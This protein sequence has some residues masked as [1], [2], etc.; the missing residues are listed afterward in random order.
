LRTGLHIHMDC[1]DITYLQLI[2]K[3]VHYI[4]WEP[5]IYA[6]I[7]G[8]REAN[9]FCA[10]WYKCEGT[11]VD[12]AKVL[13]HII[14]MASAEGET[15]AEMTSELAS[16]TEDL[17][18]YAGLNL[19]PLKKYGSVEFRQMVATH[20]FKLVLKWMNIILNLKR[21]ALESPES[22]MAIIGLTES[23]GLEKQLKW[24]FG[25][26][27]ALEMLAANPCI[28]D[29]VRQIGIPNAVEF[30]GALTESTSFIDNSKIFNGKMSKGAARWL[31]KKVE[32]EERKEP[33]LPR[34]KPSESLSF[35][36]SNMQVGDMEAVFP[37][38]PPPT[39]V[40]QGTNAAYVIVD[41]Y[42]DN[43]SFDEF[44]DDSEET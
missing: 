20:D 41:D 23:K 9:N 29:E 13:A 19:R 11:I 5:A 18:K 17:H 31:A 39:P 38:L 43:V 26:E 33:P 37:P 42:G 36:V 35:Y 1:R 15:L 12:A 30:L 7:G 25:E 40:I 3:V 10:P 2:G 14:K 32:P 27:T 28:L 6:W 4:M 8:G 44:N 16:M 24:T 21:V 34:K 22:S